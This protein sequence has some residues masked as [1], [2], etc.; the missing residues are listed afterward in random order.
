[1]TSW[2]VRFIQL[3]DTTMRGF[4]RTCSVAGFLVADQ[5]PVG[6][7]FGHLIWIV[8]QNVLEN[9]IPGIV[10]PVVT[11]E[12]PKVVGSVVEE[13]QALATFVR[14]LA[15]VL[16]MLSRLAIVVSSSANVFQITPSAGRRSKN[17][18]FSSN[19]SEISS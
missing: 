9:E 18:A 5:Q 4:L 1:M 8:V 17:S 11:E 19:S 10:L 14:Y 13:R 2:L 7:Q 6:V 16:L 15:A 12:Q 3:L